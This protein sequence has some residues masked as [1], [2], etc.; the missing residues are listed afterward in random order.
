MYRHN[1]LSPITMNNN[2]FK[3]SLQ[4][5]AAA[6]ALSSCHHV[7]LHHNVHNYRAN[8]HPVVVHK[9]VVVKPVVVHKP[10][11]VK[12]K[13]VVVNKPAPPRPKPA[14]AHKPA[15]PKPVAHNN[16]PGAPKPSANRKPN[17][18]E[19]RRA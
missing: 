10:V 15:A 19:K 1:P 11:V 5:S 8:A 17:D 12:P 16:K 14:V 6:L 4:L 7:S 13:P 2:F 3:M 18:R 9:P